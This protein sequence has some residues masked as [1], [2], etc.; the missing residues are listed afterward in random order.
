M[1]DKKKTFKEI[2]GKTRVGKFLKDN[3]PG[4]LN[5]VLSIAG[6]LVPG[7][8]GAADV[9]KDMINKSDE[10]DEA[11]KLAAIDMLKHEFA[12]RADARDLQK[13]ALQQEDK[14]SKRF[15]YYLTTAVF[16]FSA[17]IVLL[18]FWI[19]IPDKNR[20]VVNFILGVVVGTGLTGIFNYFYG[21]STGSS[22]KQEQLHKILQNGNNS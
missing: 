6:G 18:L 1:G 10:L 14:L 16:M 9:I 17:I 15:I 12:D 4:L 19:E 21:S 8:S 11:Q 7:A 13:V 20:D 3:A 2:H 22:S 5:A